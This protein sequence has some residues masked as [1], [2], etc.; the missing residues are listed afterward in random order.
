M[1]SKTFRETIWIKFCYSCLR[2]FLGPIIRIIWIKKVEGLKNIP[3]KGPCIIAANHSSF[4]DFI[5]FIAV[6]PRKIYYL[7][8]EK[9][10]KWKIWKILVKATGQIRVERQS[11]DK[12]EVYDV[13]FSLLKQGKILG[14]FPEGTR[15]SDDKIHKAYVGV[16]KFALMAQ[17]PVVPVGIKNTYKILSRHRRFP[18]IKKI[19]E[20]KIGEPI[21]FDKYYNQKN[22]KFFKKITDEIML[23]IAELS[24]KEYIYAEK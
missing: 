24:D 20:L 4:F 5:C 19:V 13:A 3:K 23:K 16:A 10:F 21:Y 6:S 12:N 2:F 17:V 7:A 11:I 18:R 14:I 8:A 1:K 15:S 22:K 9:F